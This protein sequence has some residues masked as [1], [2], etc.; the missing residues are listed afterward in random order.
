MQMRIRH[1]DLHALHAPMELR[2]LLTKIQEITGWDQYVLAEKFSV[3]QPTISRWLK[4]G[5]SR[6]DYTK[7][8]RAR[9]LLAEVRRLTNETGTDNIPAILRILGEV[10]VPDRVQWFPNGGALLYAEIPF[11]L[12][13]NHVA[14]EVTQ[15]GLVSRAHRGDLLVLGGPTKDVASLIGQD[16]AVVTTEGENLFG[17]VDTGRDDGAFSIVGHSTVLSFNVTISEA[18]PFVAVIAARAWKPSDRK[19]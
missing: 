4:E 13:E 9:Q 3:K 18:R 1:C 10:S 5:G 15:T 2:D 12:P 14:L 16:A 19:T 6:P 8:E 11:P 17:R 7:I